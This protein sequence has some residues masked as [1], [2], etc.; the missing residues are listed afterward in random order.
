MEK[1]KYD[2]FISYRR[3]GGKNYART[4][5][6]ELEKRGFRVFL[7]FDELKDGVFDKRIMDAINEAPIF[8]VILSKGALDRCVNDGDW[9]REEILYADKTNRHI[10]P[11]E[12]D[13]TFRDFP[14]NLPQEVKLVLG[15]HQFSQIDTETL[16]QESIDKMVRERILPYV[17]KGID[18]IPIEKD[19]TQ[20]AE[21]HIEVDADCNLLRFKKL[22]KV[23]HSG[24]DNVVHLM[25]GKHKVEFVSEEYPDIKL[26]Q[27]ITI[28]SIHYSDFIEISLSEQITIRKQEEIRIQEEQKRL[29][30][31]RRLE[32]QRRLEE[33]RKLEEQK[34]I[35]KEKKE[36]KQKEK[37]YKIGTILQDLY[38]DKVKHEAMNADELASEAILM[39]HN[40]KYRSALRLYLEAVKK[41]RQD[42]YARIGQIYL[43][44]LGVEENV[45]QAFFWYEKAAEKGEAKAQ[46]MVGDMYYYGSAGECDQAQ[47]AV[48][49]EK[50]SD[51]DDFVAQYSLGYMYLEGIGVPK[52]IDKAK[53]LL[54]ESAQHGYR[55]A[56]EKLKELEKIQ[57]DEA[58]ELSKK[59]NDLL[60]KKRWKEGNAFLHQLVSMDIVYP[61]KAHDLYL[62]GVS[63]E[64]GLGIEKN[65]DKAI[66]FYKESFDYGGRWGT[67]SSVALGYMYL[68]GEGVEKNHKEAMKWYKIAAELGSDVAQ[69]E[70]GEMYYIGVGGETNYKEAE[71]WY[72]KAAD[73]GHAKAQNR[74]GLIY[75]EGKGV[76]KDY[77]LAFKWYLKSAEGGYEWGQYNVALY[78]HNGW[79]IEQDDKKALYWYLKAAEKGNNTAQNSVGNIYYRG[80]GVEIDYKES[81][82]WY[83]KSAEGG[84]GWG[85]LNLGNMYFDGYG[86][87][88]N[89]LEAMKWYKLTKNSSIEEVKEKTLKKLKWIEDWE[90][91]CNNHNGL[92]KIGITEEGTYNYDKSHNNYDKDKGEYEQP[93]LRFGFAD[94][95]G[96]EI[97]KCT[98][99]EVGDFHSERALVWNDKK[100]LGIIDT[101]GNII[102][103]CSKKYESVDIIDDSYV[104]TFEGSFYEL[105]DLETGKAIVDTVTYTK[106][107]D[108]FVDGYLYVEKF[109]FFGK[110][111]KGKIDKEGNFYEEK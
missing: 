17:S 103:P 79:G 86:V 76:E 32:E 87:E 39:E 1:I 25:P 15:P 111:K 7:D 51:Q 24:E 20:G 11:V 55:K 36:K 77:K 104:R 80:S 16:L 109:K 2:I 99:F 14:E 105:Y 34:R 41:G 96:K 97:I 101:K 38:A 8:L 93:I 35:E 10:V 74:L 33:E 61:S 59:A 28:P 110:D 69:F 62:L 72:L 29:E 46:K 88:R 23:L 91:V 66:S 21:I 73:Q 78:Y 107:G 100:R 18:S 106:M 81:V 27:I 49:Y 47:A 83:K 43:N 90:M 13:K 102:M 53:Q 50:A 95:T 98:W 56:N 85:L 65:K 57:I 19:N 37:L 31:A 92:H 22:L 26:F 63:Y 84:Y 60:N 44:G 4:L 67:H 54:S 5:K 40:L 82:K 68:R 64:L 30:E 6:P 89:F 58:E 75:G 42:D 70:I 94:K 9:V 52:N 71:K 48:W 12:V 108:R 45:E 3:I